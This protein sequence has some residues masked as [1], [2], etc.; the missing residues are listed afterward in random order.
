[1]VGLA[2]MQ[3]K[4]VLAEAASATAAPSTNA[5]QA[6]RNTS[7]EKEPAWQTPNQAKKEKKKAKR[8]A[9]QQAAEAAA[10]ASEKGQL[11]TAKPSRSLVQLKLKLEQ[12]QLNRS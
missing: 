1:M 7:P 4:K 8:L 11:T 2:T 6:K 3:G 12:D 9:K 10:A 5:P